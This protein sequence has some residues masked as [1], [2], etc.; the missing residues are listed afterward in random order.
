MILLIFIR[1]ENIEQGVKLK[2]NLSWIVSFIGENGS[3]FT[4]MRMK[5]NMMNKSKSTYVQNIKANSTSY[6]K[7][8]EKVMLIITQR[9]HRQS[10]S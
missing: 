6:N 8:S 7:V 2:A 1:G 9:L 3:I 10:N 5:K 4:L